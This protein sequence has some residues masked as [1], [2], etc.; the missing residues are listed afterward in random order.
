MPY[1][2]SATTGGWVPSTLPKNKPSSPQSTH[3]FLSDDDDGSSNNNNNNNTIKKNDP[4]IAAAAATSDATE[5]DTFDMKEF[6]EILKL[7]STANDVVTMNNKNGKNEN[8]EAEGFKN[9]CSVL[10]AVLDWTASVLQNDEIQEDIRRENNIAVAAANNNNAATTTTGLTIRTSVLWVISMCHTLII[11]TI[12]SPRYLSRVEPAEAQSALQMF[13]LH[14]NS[15]VTRFLS[16]PVEKQSEAPIR[17]VLVTTRG[18]FNGTSSNHPMPLSVSFSELSKEFDRIL[19]SCRGSGGEVTLGPWYKDKFSV[20]HRFVAYEKVLVFAIAIAGVL[21]VFFEYSSFSLVAFASAIAIDFVFL[22]LM[23]KTDHQQRKL[24]TARARERAFS[25]TTHRMLM[26]QFVYTGVRI[27]NNNYTNNNNNNPRRHSG[28]NEIMAPS[29]PHSEVSSG[30]NV[31]LSLFSGMPADGSPSA[32]MNDN[33]NNPAAPPPAAPPLMMPRLVSD[34]NSADTSDENAPRPRRVTIDFEAAAALQPTSS[35]HTAVPNSSR[36]TAEDRMESSANGGS[37]ADHRGDPVHVPRSGSLMFDVG[38][39]EPRILFIGA[40]VLHE[41]VMLIGVHRNLN[42]AFWN[43][44]AEKVTGFPSEACLG[45]SV[46]G[47]LHERCKS[48]FEQLADV[49]DMLQGYIEPMEVT[50]FHATNHT[51]TLD[52]HL[53]PAAFVSGGRAGFFIIG[54]LKESS[55]DANNTAQQRL[56]VHQAATHAARVARFC[57]EHVASDVPSEISQASVQALRY[58]NALHPIRFED[59]QAKWSGFVAIN[60]RQYIGDLTSLLLMNASTIT[61]S[62]HAPRI[63]CDVEESLPEVVRWDEDKLT[64]MISYLIHNATAAQAKNILIRNFMTSHTSALGEQL[65]YINF[66]VQ[67][68]GIGI[69]DEKL[70]EI[71]RA[72]AFSFATCASARV[73]RRSTESPKRLAIITETLEKFGAWIR[74]DTHLHH[75]SA[76]RTTVTITLPCIPARGFA[77]VDGTPTVNALSAPLGS[78]NFASTQL[79]PR[80]SKDH[81]GLSTVSSGNGGNGNGNGNG[82]RNSPRQIRLSVIVV[83]DNALYRAALAN[84]LWHSGHSLSIASDFD[85]VERLLETQDVNLLML[86][87]TMI[88]RDRDRMRDLKTKNVSVCLLL[89]PSTPEDEVKEFGELGYWTLRS[90]VNGSELTTTLYKASSWALEARERQA[91]IT[92]IRNVFQQ[93]NSC[94]WERLEKLGSG[95]FGQVYKAKDLTTGGIMAVKVIKI[96]AEDRDAEQKVTDLVN[97]VALLRTL[98]HENIIHYLYCERG[99]GC[100]NVFMEYANGGTVSDVVS[101]HTLLTPQKA[102]PYLRELLRAV[103]FLHENNIMHRDIKCA[104]LMLAN[105]KVKLGD[106]GTACQL[107]EKEPTTNEMKGTLRFMAPE[108]AK[109]EQYGLACDVWSIGCTL[110]EMLTGKQPMPHIEGNYLQVIAALCR[111][112]HGE[113]IPIPDSITHVLARNFIANCLHVDPAMRPSVKTLLSDPFLTHNDLEDRKMEMFA[114]S[115]AAAMGAASFVAPRRAT[116]AIIKNNENNHATEK[117]SNENNNG[118]GGRA[119]SPRP[120]LVYATLRA[121]PL[122]AEEPSPPESESATPRQEQHLVSENDDA[123]TTKQRRPSRPGLSKEPSTSDYFDLKFSTWRQTEADAQWIKEQQQKDKDN[124][125]AAA[126]A[127]A[128]AAAAMDDVGCFSGWGMENFNAKIEQAI[129]SKQQQQQASC[130]LQSNSNNNKSGSAAE[131]SEYVRRV[132]IDPRAGCWSL[133]DSKIED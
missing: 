104:N 2:S 120:S 41:H 101:E 106:F 122:F 123:P 57:V 8:D 51:V 127:K 110:V 50:M 130:S 133:Y 43:A 109:E 91:Q 24:N 60:L 86:D 35:V 90:P 105:G 44:G 61:G 63:N 65:K 84:M 121:I 27:F 94:V 54:H 97:E 67:D 69:S 78:D 36:S 25:C 72:G 99:D 116:M 10:S 95:A 4:T 92:R 117:S 49:V 81:N 100:I 66:S 118:G 23:Y 85:D 48:R 87:A 126:E 15:K 17:V 14:W 5:N 124:E 96:S 113:S 32:A 30:A 125:K 73:P 6:G 55:A 16:I 34:A 68:D 19:V 71:H 12:A 75:S 53:A 115:G 11:S 22:L 76:R 107:T 64:D 131:S 128:M 79:A 20:A 82:G 28:T 33:N 80:D 74:C 98:E 13:V 39:R 26:E 21:A 37:L 45:S 46:L 3:L 119:V 29:P 114:P 112:E 108:V 31:Q 70:E 129:A 93:H 18:D 77:G 40:N 88:P 9:V 111:M 83:E 7:L 102:I 56:L 38:S 89:D 47:L 103:A 62:Q 52:V 42:I 1:P 59:L 132:S 58:V